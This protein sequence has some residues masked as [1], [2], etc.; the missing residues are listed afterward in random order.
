[1]P[2]PHS[3]QYEEDRGRWLM[4][5]TALAVRLAPAQPVPDRSESSAM[6]PQPL[7][8]GGESEE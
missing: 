5:L 1:M 8:Q 3:K 2:Q 4:S 7:P 6:R